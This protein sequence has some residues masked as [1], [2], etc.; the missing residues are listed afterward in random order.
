M[1]LIHICCEVTGGFGARTVE[2]RDVGRP[3]EWGLRRNSTEGAGWKP[4]APAAARRAGGIY[5]LDG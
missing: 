2:E 1:P 3:E 5:R 4:H